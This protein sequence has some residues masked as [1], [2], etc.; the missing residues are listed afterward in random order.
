[1]D[2]ATARRAVL[3]YIDALSKQLVKR[4]LDVLCFPISKCFC[5]ELMP[6]SAQICTWHFLPAFFMSFSLPLSDSVRAA[7]QERL[8]RVVC[9]CQRMCDEETGGEHSRFVKFPP[10]HVSPKSLCQF[11]GAGAQSPL[12]NPPETRHSEAARRKNS[13][14]VSTAAEKFGTLLRTI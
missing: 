5:E 9:H 3:S 13:T 6:Q 10:S 4:D 14:S 7:E 12:T 8:G 11:P 1:M 2:K